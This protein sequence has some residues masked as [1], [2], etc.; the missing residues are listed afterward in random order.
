MTDDDDGV[1][2]L[3]SYA[4]ERRERAEA[5]PAPVEVVLSLP[6]RLAD[7]L[8]ADAQAAGEP[9]EAFVN[10]RVIEYLRDYFE[11]ELRGDDRLPLFP[12]VV[13]LHPSPAG[14]EEGPQSEDAEE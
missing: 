14:P 10:R 1:A 4:A 6:E 13:D 3:A 2:D 11:E 9:F 5:E 8:H 7:L 12:D